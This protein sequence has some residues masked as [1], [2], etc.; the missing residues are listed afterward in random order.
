MTDFRKLRDK[1][2][3]NQEKSLKINNMCSECN[4]EL[5]EDFEKGFSYCTS[6]GTCGERLMDSKAEWSVYDGNT[7]KCNIRCGAPIDKFFPVKSMN[8]YTKRKYRYIDFNN[9]I[10]YNEKS[11][12]ESFRIMSIAC[13]KGKLANPI[14]E[15]AKI[16][17]FEI[18]TSKHMSGSRKGKKVIKRGTKNVYG[19]YGGCLY[20]ACIIE[21]YYLT[22]TEIA[23]LFDVV[24]K[25]ITG[26][27]NMIKKSLRSFQVIEY[28]VPKISFDFVERHCYKIGLNKNDIEEVMNII[29]NSKKLCLVSNHRPIS[30][31]SGCVML[32]IELKKLKISKQI[33][34]DSFV[35]TVNT[36]DK[37]YEKL[38]PF[39]DVLVSEEIT[40]MVYKSLVK[41]NLVFEK[42][43]DDNKDHEN[44]AKET[45]N[46]KK[47]LEETK[48]FKEKMN[49]LYNNYH[50]N[51]KRGRKPKHK[52]DDSSV[53]ESIDESIIR[54][55]EEMNMKENDDCDIKDDISEWSSSDNEESDDEN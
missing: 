23:D 27:I 38:Y 7:D 16:L 14:L 36:I 6:C 41:N 46:F 5:Y 25:F 43:E 28:L 12:E 10:P 24:P 44:I 31:I 40:E 9:F 30:V 15:T 54:R 52:D 53:A 45:F 50:K 21:D 26:G 18:H 35:I 22:Q 4:G 34:V 49:T 11:L 2:L 17:Y 37:V 51:N 19:R 47:E 55:F 48:R 33:V 20:Y 1:Y 39:R 13:S 3:K 32:Y 8:V 29:T 42:T